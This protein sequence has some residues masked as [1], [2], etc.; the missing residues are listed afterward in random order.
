MGLI[1]KSGEFRFERLT[2]M[3]KGSRFVQQVPAKEVGRARLS[4]PRSGRPSRAADAPRLSSACAPGLRSS[5]AASPTGASKSLRGSV[6]LRR[7]GVCGISYGM[8]QRIVLWAPGPNQP[9]CAHEGDRSPK[10]QG[11][12]PDGSLMQ[13]RR[14]SRGKTPGGSPER[15]LSPRAT[16][17]AECP[18]MEVVGHYRNSGA[19]VWARIR[20]GLGATSNGCTYKAVLSVD[21]GSSFSG[22]NPF[23]GRRCFVPAS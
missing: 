5:S 13:R 18:A 9:A 3:S 11:D 4:A 1:R 17:A 15:W 23:G 19:P 22:P 14:P 16:L 21:Y 8:L 2:G 7:P 20:R 12:R 10:S 6:T